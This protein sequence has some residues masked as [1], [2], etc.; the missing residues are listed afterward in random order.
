MGTLRQQQGFTLIELMIVVAIIGILASIAISVYQNLT[1]QAQIS[2]EDGTIAAANSAGVIYLGKNSV[3]PDGAS[4]MISMSPN[5]TSFGELRGGGQ[6][7]VGHAA[8]D[9][10]TLQMVVNA[11]ATGAHPTSHAHTQAAPC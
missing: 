2:A 3:P 10:C 9:W 11:D 1:T 4:V 5:L 6:A 7:N 8:V